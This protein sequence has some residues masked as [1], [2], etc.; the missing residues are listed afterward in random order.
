MIQNETKI[1]YFLYA[2]KSSEGEDRQIQSIDD[3]IN[4]L[5]ELAD[6]L[7][8]NIVKIY[9]ESKSAK[10]PNNRPIFM[11]MMEK[12]KAGE[13]N[14]IL[15]WQINR[16]SR[17]PV[18]SGEI[19]WLSQQGVLKSIQT[20]DRQFLPTDNV[21][22]F[23]V[24]SGMANQYILDLKMNTA[25][26]RQSK[27]KKGWLPNY[28]PLGYINVKNEMG[29]KIIEKDPVRFDLIRKMWELM[30]TGNYTPPAILEIA[31]N[32]WG[33]TTKKQRRR[34]I[35]P[36]SRSGIYKIFTSPFYAGVLCY[37]GNEY[38]GSHAPMITL[39]E[40]DRVQIILGR[41]GKPRPQKHHFAYTGFIRCGE[42]GCLITGIEKHKHI[43]STGEV[44]KYIYYHCTRKKKHINCSQKKEVK[45]EIL[46]KQI[47]E[48]LTKYTILPEFKDWALEYLNEHND[49]EIKDRQT[50][51][52]TQHSALTRTQRELDELT[53]MRY[54]ELISDE[55]F[56]QEKN[57]L[58]KRIARLKEELRTTENRAEEWLELTEKTFNFATYARNAFITGDLQT[59][60][61]IVTALGLNP[62]IK[63]GK[64]AIYPHKWLIPIAEGYP[65]LEKEYQRL[66]PMKN[67][68]LNAKTPVL[69]SVRTR[70]LRGQDLNLRPRGYGPRELPGCSTPR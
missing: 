64:L 32:E 58:Q 37:D 56:I 7:D 62:T 29:E 52:E 5:K 47:E 70:W 60:K 31:N 3:Q 68:L 34:G 25:R 61:E 2:R 39:E 67:G 53:K 45:E 46:E 23:S 55:T 11:E 54:R 16:L 43:K 33:L 50:I 21:L 19:S 9:T 26:G 35:K 48:I 57:D 59:K 63:D 40:F 69:A 8:L 51:Y 20:I 65:A 38:H 42:C 14:G 36:L 30:L 27:L 41:K 1:K 49:Q 15:C 6:R 12:I 28:A 24:E 4:R 18:D 44:R 13:A 10:Q 66:E 17:N 22:L